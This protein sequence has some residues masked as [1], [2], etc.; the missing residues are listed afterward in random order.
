[1][2]VLTKEDGIWLVLFKDAETEDEAIRCLGEIQSVTGKYLFFSNDRNK[3]LTIA[4]DEIENH[5]F[6]EAKVPLVGKQVREYVLCLYY[7]NA[8]RLNELRERLEK[9]NMEGVRLV[10]W[11]TDDETRRGVYSGEFRRE[12]ARSSASHDSSQSSLKRFYPS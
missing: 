10:S 12:R 3:L 5:G 6:I 9:R 1:M 8:D 11:K 4:R 7:K 2:T